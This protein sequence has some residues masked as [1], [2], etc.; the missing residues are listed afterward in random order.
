MSQIPKRK[1]LTYA[2]AY[3]RGYDA[4]WR[5]RMGAV[6]ASPCQQVV[7]EGMVDAW[8]HGYNDGRANRPSRY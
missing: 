8:Q 4:G 6:H 5:L 7:W 2:Q 1:R 3:C